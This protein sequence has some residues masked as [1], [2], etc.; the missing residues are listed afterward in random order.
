MSEKI[1]SRKVYDYVI[2]QIKVNKWVPGDKI[3]T[4]KELCEILGVS[5]I[6]VREALEQCS[7]LGILEKRKGAGTYVS[8]IDINHI[9]KNIIP[10]LSLTPMD[11]MDVL[12]FRLSFE[13]GIVSEFI[14]HHTSDDISEL[15]KSFLKMKNH[16]SERQEFYTADYNFHS[17]LARGTKNPIIVSINAML[18]GILMSSQE[19]TNIKIGPEVGMKYHK[20]ILTAIKKNDEPMATLLMKRHIEAT[21]ESV[22]NANCGT[23]KKISDLI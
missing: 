6:A 9:M 14:A 17:I 12:R 4:E 19:L 20:E 8:E 16:Y 21:I 11:L 23:D 18:T 3:F 22:E 10:L 15:E 1:L 7:A 5:R 2:E 13:P